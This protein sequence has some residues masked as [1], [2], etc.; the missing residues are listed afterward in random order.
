MR[1]KTLSWLSEESFNQLPKELRDMKLEY[2]R[3]YTKI[4]RREKSL[5]KRYEKYKMD[6]SEL[7]EWKR[8]RTEKFN[9]LINLH[10]TFVPIVSITY[11]KER[12]R[13]GDRSNTWSI[14]M[15]LGGK[16]FNIYIG[17]DKNVRIRLNELTQTNK[18]Y[19]EGGSVKF[20]TRYEQEKKR[21]QSEVKKYIQP[22]IV[23]KLRELNE[24]FNGFE[25]W[26]QLYKNKELKGMDFFTD[27]PKPLS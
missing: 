4:Q 25:T 22:N 13:W 26:C 27:I 5:V 3:L 16:T 15:K 18:Y 12:K 9:Q 24:E 1:K 6:K 17:T 11:S 23:K 8:E 2:Q 14:T 7:R 20:K 21:I 19:Q 10:E